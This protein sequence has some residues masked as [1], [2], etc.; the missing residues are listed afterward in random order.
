[1]K[2]DPLKLKQALCSLVDAA[3][4]GFF[5][6]GDELYW[7]VPVESLTDPTAEVRFA[8]S[9]ASELSQFLVGVP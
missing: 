6:V 3:S 5:D 7:F 8:A 2:I 9:I 4:A 1:M